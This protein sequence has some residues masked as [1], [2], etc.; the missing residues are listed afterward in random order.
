MYKIDKQTDSILLFDN[1]KSYDHQA[2]IIA[3]INREWEYSNQCLEDV[4]E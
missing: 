2:D 4:G 3:E 1:S